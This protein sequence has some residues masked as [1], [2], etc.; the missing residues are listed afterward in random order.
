MKESYKGE[1]EG[2]NEFFHHKGL[3]RETCIKPQ[4]A[5]KY[6]LVF[7]VKCTCEKFKIEEVLY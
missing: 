2:V 1:N 3:M 5:V 7:I 6:H 4:R